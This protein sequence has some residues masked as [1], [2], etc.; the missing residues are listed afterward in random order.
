MTRPRTMSNI[1][2]EAPTSSTRG[3]IGKI[4]LFPLPDRGGGE[5]A[6]EEAEEAAAE[7]QRS[8]EGEK[9]QNHERPSGAGRTDVEAEWSKDAKPGREDDT[10][11]S[12]L[13]SEGP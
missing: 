6:D 11:T 1:N 3:G 5:D 12:I 7:P 9:R 2:W 10:R 4:S 13:A 8:A